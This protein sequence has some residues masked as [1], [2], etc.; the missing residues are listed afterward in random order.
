MWICKND[1]FVSIVENSNDKNTLMV[2][3]RREEDLINVIGEQ[4]EIVITPKNDYRYRA[5]IS[6]HEVARIIS[7]HIINI[8]YPNFK[9]S[10]SDSD[11]HKLYGNFWYQHYKYQK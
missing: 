4:H 3:A 5:F 11:L 9:N 10:V 2:R 7:N 1:G 8:N 6:K